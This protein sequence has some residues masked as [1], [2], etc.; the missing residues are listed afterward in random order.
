MTGRQ[1]LGEAPW[2]EAAFLA[3]IWL[4]NVIYGAADP[5]AIYGKF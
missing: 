2:I 4:L 1:W 5:L 3:A